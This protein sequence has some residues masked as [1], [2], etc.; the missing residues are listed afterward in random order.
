M[1][2]DFFYPSFVYKKSNIYIYIIYIWENITQYRK[3]CRTKHNFL[4]AYYTKDSIKCNINRKN[5]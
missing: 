5:I 2:V 3:I 4:L 1:T